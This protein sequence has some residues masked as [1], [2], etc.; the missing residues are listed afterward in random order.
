MT[1]GELRLKLEEIAWKYGNDFE[2]YIADGAYIN[3]EGEEQIFYSPLYE[4]DIVTSVYPEYIYI[5]K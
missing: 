4:Q 1:L 3:E 2:I 5:S